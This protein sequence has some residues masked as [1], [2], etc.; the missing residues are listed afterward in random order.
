MICSAT[1]AEL[2]AIEGGLR[3]KEEAAL[4]YYPVVWLL[5]ASYLGPRL[6]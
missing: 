2:G 5:S 4:S 3:W 6:L 1:A